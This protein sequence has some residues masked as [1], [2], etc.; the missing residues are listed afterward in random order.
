MVLLK[1][2]A[3]RLPR[4]G[5]VL[6]AAYTPSAGYGR[7][8]RCTLPWYAIDPHHTPLRRGYVSALCGPCWRELARPADRLDYYRALVYGT[9]G[10]L[11]RWPAV[12][13]AVL[14]EGTDPAPGA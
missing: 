4:W 7:C 14:A 1:Y 8:Q 2:C 3:G 13:A 10:S 11:D 5:R 9:W 6:L 12:R